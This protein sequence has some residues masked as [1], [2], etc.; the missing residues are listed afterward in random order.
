VKFRRA[1]TL[2]SYWHEGRLL[3]ENYATG[4]V[5]HLTPLAVAILDRASDW[6]T[7]EQLARALKAAPGPGFHRVL[8]ALER[9]T[10]VERQ[11]ARAVSGRL[12]AWAP[13]LPHA[14]LFHFGTKDQQYLSPRA[15][16]LALRAQSRATPC[17]RPTKAYP[18]RRRVALPAPHDVRTPVDAALLARRT[19]RRFSRRPVPLADVAT[20]LGLTWGV[21]QQVRDDQGNRI[22]LK[23]SPSG[24]A[25]H[26][27]EVYLAAFNVSGLPPSLYHYDAARHVLTRVRAVRAGFN[28]LRYLPQQPWY[29][30]AAALFLMTAVVG[31]ELWKYPTPRAYRALLIDA[32]HLTQT[33]C[34]VAT[35][36]GL[37]PFC[38]M[39][40]DDS[41]IERDLGLDG[42]TEIALYA[43]GCGARP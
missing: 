25:T 14:G 13:W 23:T 9:A 29:R 10:L 33:C 19:S 3:A 12:D 39:A 37:G 27:I 18:A 40:L 11:R 43:A 35:A 2:V 22:V 31:R 20:L 34:L 7:P 30:G 41:R 16:T 5:A 4:T 28:P 1:P 36:L 26:P 15:A 32:G 6:T 38:S 42:A 17:P 24:G 21:Q 8:R